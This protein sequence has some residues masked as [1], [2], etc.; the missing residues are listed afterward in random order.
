MVAS[1]LWLNK[2]TRIFWSHIASHMVVLAATYTASAKLSATDFCFMLHQDTTLD[3]MLKQHPSV[4]FLS[5]KLPAQFA[6]MN[7][8]SL[9]PSPQV[10]LNPYLIVPHKY[11]KMC[12]VVVQCTLLDPTINSLRVLTAKQISGLV[13]TRYMREL[14]SCLYKVGSMSSSSDASIFLQLVNRRRHW[15]TV[16]HLESLQNLCNIFPLTKEDLTVLLPYFQA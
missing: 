10:L 11:L 8:H 2:L 16:L 15:S 3:P 4:L 6:S 5:T 13:L 1:N 12:L 7:P 9:T 14:I